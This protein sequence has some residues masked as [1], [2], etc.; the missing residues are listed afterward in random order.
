MLRVVN[1]TFSELFYCVLHASFTERVV[2]DLSEL[3]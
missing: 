2:L 3:L 1:R